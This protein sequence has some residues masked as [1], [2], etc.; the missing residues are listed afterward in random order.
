[1]DIPAKNSNFDGGFTMIERELYDWTIAA[2]LGGPELKIVHAIIRQ[3]NGYNR[4]PE[5]P[6]SFRFIAK[7]TGIDHRNV[8]K[9]IKKLLAKKIILRRVGDKMKWGKSVYIY[10][11]NKMTCRLPNASKEHCRVADDSAVVKNTPAAV[12]NETPIKE[13]KKIYKPEIQAIMDK[14]KNYKLPTH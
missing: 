7:M 2:K 3:T 9:K 5:A 12:V 10:R 13:I 4:R 11:I 14:L 6:M 8:E 1:M